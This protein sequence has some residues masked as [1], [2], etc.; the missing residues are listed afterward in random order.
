[1]GRIIV[2]DALAPGLA[3]R[4]AQEGDT[5][6]QA[7]IARRLVP[8]LRHEPPVSAVRTNDQGAVWTLHRLALVELVDH[9]EDLYRE[10]AVALPRARLLELAS[11]ARLPGDP[12]RVID[13]WLTG[14]DVAPPLL[15]EPERG[16][17]TLADPHAAERDFIADRG[18]R[19]IG[20]RANGRAAKHRKAE[21]GKPKD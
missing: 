12:Q 19:A 8:E 5:A 3:A 4:L 16:R 2:G 15:A 1:M 7:S 6:R 20:G 18:R 9:A 17:F 13:S 11:Q 21:R 14:D 10:G